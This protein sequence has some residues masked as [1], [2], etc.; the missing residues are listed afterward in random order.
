MKKVFLLLVLSFVSVKP[1]ANTFLTYSLSGGR[2]GDNLVAYARCK[3]LSWKYS[4]SML[5]LP[6]NYSNKFVFHTKDQSITPERKQQ[7]EQQVMIVDNE[8]VLNNPQPNTLYI[9]KYIGKKL[10]RESLVEFCLENSEF[11]SM[12]ISLVQ[13]MRRSDALELPE[14]VVTIAVHVRKAGNSDPPM[15]SEQI[16]EFDWY[17][18]NIEQYGKIPPARGWADTGGHELKF[19]PEQYYIDLIS[20]VSE[21][22]GNVPIYVY[23]FTNFQPTKLLQRIQTAVDKENILFECEKKEI[24]LNNSNIILKNLFEITQFDILI[25]AD[26]NFSLVA[27]LIGNHVVCISPQDYCWNDN[28]LIIKEAVAMVK[29]NTSRPFKKYSLHKQGEEFGKELRLLFRE[30]ISG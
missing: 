2:L 3:Y 7:F 26:S 21:L 15:M 20:F 9:A 30:K 22:L 16:Y 8:T 14:D 17:H 6:F 13:P 27:D 10:Y 28:K 23:I 19:P 24:N 29:D 12:L 11:R 25:R 1:L 5:Y 18:S 4:I